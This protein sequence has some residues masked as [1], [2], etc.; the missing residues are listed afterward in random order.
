MRIIIDCVALAKE[1]DDRF[2]SVCVSVRQS[3]QGAIALKA[4]AKHD[5]YQS[6]NFT[7][8]AMS[9]LCLNST[10]ACMFYE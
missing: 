4:G 9:M 10:T 3:T 1:G 2:G 7:T 6:D 8:L 5:L